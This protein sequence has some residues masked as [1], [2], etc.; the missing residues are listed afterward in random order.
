MQKNKKKTAQ[1]V[2]KPL[3]YGNWH[4]KQARK[5]GVKLMLNIFL[6]TL[7]YFALC[8]MLNFNA[9]W[10]C[11][12]SNAVVVFVVGYYLYN[13]GMQRGEAEAANAEIAY[14]RREQGKPLAAEEEAAGYH[15]LKGHYIAVIA[16]LPFVAVTLAYALTVQPVLYTPGG[17]PSWVQAFMRQ[18]EFGD[19]LGYYQT[20]SGITAYIIL[21]IVARAM[22]MPFVSVGSQLGATAS[23]WVERLAPLWVL[24]APL[25]YGL[26]YARGESLRARVHTGIVASQRRMKRKQQRERRERAR[27]EPEQLI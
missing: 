21:R 1:I 25:G 24:V 11:V 9:L 27:K 3:L 5:L 7:L 19:A 2:A 6:A 22:V 17:M 18:T 4:G 26:G 8:I 14:E 15:P 10:L 20:G 23:L 13:Q 16:S 12:I